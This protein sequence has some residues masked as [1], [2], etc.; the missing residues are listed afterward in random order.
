MATLTSEM[1]DKI[2]EFV[3]GKPGAI[4]SKIDEIICSIQEN[5]EIKYVD[6]EETD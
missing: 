4:Y 3:S 1:A 6:E 2:L 5:V